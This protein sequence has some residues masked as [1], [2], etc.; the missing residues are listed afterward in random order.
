M[1][2]KKFFIFSLIAASLLFAIFQEAA[3]G[4]AALFYNLIMMTQAK[5]YRQAQTSKNFL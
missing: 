2:S 4:A 1:S 5:K 3:E